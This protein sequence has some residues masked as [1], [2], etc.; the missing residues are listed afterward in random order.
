MAL[1][2]SSQLTQLHSCLCEEF[3]CNGS[4][5]FEQFC[6]MFTCSEDVRDIVVVFHSSFDSSGPWFPGVRVQSD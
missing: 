5:G 3:H 2:L 4:G 6:D 1:A